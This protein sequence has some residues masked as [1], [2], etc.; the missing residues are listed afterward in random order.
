MRDD[1]VDVTIELPEER[2]R[3]SVTQRWKRGTGF[4]VHVEVSPDADLTEHAAV[5]EAINLLITHLTNEVGLSSFDDGRRRGL[6]EAGRPDI[7]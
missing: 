4:S 2:F 6:D 7:T 1:Y 5:Q 3:V